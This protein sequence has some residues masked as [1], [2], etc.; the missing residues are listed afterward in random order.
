M[1]EN[2][3]LQKSHAFW[4]E[5]TRSVAERS[6]PQ[7]VPV[8]AIIVNAAGEVIAEGWNTR[9]QD[10]DPAGHAEMMALKLAG[11][12]LQ[13]WRLTDCT[14]Y[15]TLEPCPMC[16]SAVIQARL[17]RIVFGAWDPVQG[18]C[19]SVFN[20]TTYYPESVEVTGG[21]QEAACRAQ[22]QDFFQ[23]IR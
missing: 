3:S 8:G 19:G 9:E 5:Q 16:A 11:A 22:L 14:L 10:A 18:A 21:I 1:P 2:R 17:S 6:L 7:D 15:V 23:T 20:M 12:V 13:N 4:I